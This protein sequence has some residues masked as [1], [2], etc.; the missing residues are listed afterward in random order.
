MTRKELARQVF[1]LLKKEVSPR[2]SPKIWQAI[3][4]TDDKS[5]LEEY[6]RLVDRH[7]VKEGDNV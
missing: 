1:V 3:A 4:E 5:L 2:L 7:Y 6:E